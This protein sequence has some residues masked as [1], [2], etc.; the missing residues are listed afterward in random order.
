MGSPAR[1]Q[2]D[3][4]QAESPVEVEIELT[5]LDLEVLEDPSSDRGAVPAEEGL[6]DP[7]IPRIRIARAPRGDVTE[8]TPA[9]AR[10]T[11]APPP[12]PPAALRRS[13]SRI[14]SPRVPP[15]SSRVP[16]EPSAASGS[17]SGERPASPS[18][19]ALPAPR[20]PLATRA[21]PRR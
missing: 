21:A 1:E 12:P 4:A 18:P 3:A 19:R 17:A 6:D 16:I 2:L 8:R 11:S 14:P 10:R 9:Q 13:S 5:E 15:S 7:T 20:A